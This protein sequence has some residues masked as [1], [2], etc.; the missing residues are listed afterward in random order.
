MNDNM[1]L[2]VSYE[3]GSAEQWL[4]G[5]DDVLAVF[6]FGRSPL[7]STDPRHVPVALPQLDA[8]G[9]L[10]VWRCDGPIK[11]GSWDLLRFAQGDQLTMGHIALDLRRQADMREA[12]RQAYD[13]LQSYLQQSPHPWPLKIWNYIPA[14]N[15]GEGDEELY[16]QFCLGRAD[17]VLIDPGDLPP[18]P[19]ATAI[20]AP[21]TEPA[22]QVYFLSGALPGMDIE[23]PRQVSAWRY[24]RQYGPRSPL[25]SRGT[26]ITLNGRRQFLISGTASVVGHQTHHENQVANQLSE[27]LRNV[28]SLFDEGH[29]LMGDARARL[30]S[31]GILKVYIRNPE[32]YEQ[33]RRTLEAETPADIPR[34]YLQGDICRENLLT[35]IDGIVSCA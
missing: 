17:A 21:A 12:S 33:I 35:E 18:L 20:G 14:I 10:E 6:E 32:D 30:D 28:Q 34:I 7:A 8:P 2:R 24:P 5:P 23:N 19:A 1:S 13:V 15:Q 22:L 27:S 3:Q 26:I 16:R 9:R 29:R 25:F 11:C 31:D 4:A